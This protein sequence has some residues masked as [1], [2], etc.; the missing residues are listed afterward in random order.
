M[1][2]VAEETAYFFNGKVPAL[3]LMGKGVRF[4]A[5]TWMRVANAAAVAQHV[6]DM[7]REVF[8]RLQGKAI[9]NATLMSEADV[10]EFERSL[11]AP[12]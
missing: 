11:T 1:P 5:G 4:P 9:V 10:E 8:L 12:G 6:E 3:A 2:K 7:L